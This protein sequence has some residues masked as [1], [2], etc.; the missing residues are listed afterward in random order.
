MNQFNLSSRHACDTAK[1]N[2]TGCRCTRMVMSTQYIKSSIASVATRDVV[3]T[4]IGHDDTWLPAAFVSFQIGP[5]SHS[6]CLQPA[7]PRYWD[8]TA[9]V[10]NTGATTGSGP[11][12]PLVQRAGVRVHAVGSR[13]T[14][15]TA[16]TTTVTTGRGEPFWLDAARRQLLNPGRQRGVEFSL[17]E[18]PHLRRTCPPRG[19]VRQ[20]GRHA[21][22]GR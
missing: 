5:R 8:R 20:V 12:S 22:L 16:S 15:A 13:R 14:A 19:A 9:T 4:D 18:R 21:V 17:E 2:S 3:H 1:P 11:A 6:A 10:T 7:G